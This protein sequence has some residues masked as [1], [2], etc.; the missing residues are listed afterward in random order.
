MRAEAI[1]V[2]RRGLDFERLAFADVSRNF[3]RRRALSRVT[4]TF[5]AGTITGLLGRNGSGKST[6][7]AIAATILAPSSGAVRYGESTAAQ[8]GAD[9]RRAIGLVAHELHLYAELTARENLEFFAAL[10]GL[11]DPRTAAREGLERANLAT[12]ADDPVAGFSRGMRQRLSLERALLHAPRLLLLDEPFTGL[13]EASAAALSSRLRSLREQGCIT[14]V[15][16]H[17]RA[18]AARLVDRALILQD[19]RLLRIEEDPRRIGEPES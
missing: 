11:P 5:E 17:D 19:G 18:Q 15:S 8:A 6:L 13:D 2:P 12:R 10:Y 3:G 9:L 14:L 7:L 1:P 4:A 16:I